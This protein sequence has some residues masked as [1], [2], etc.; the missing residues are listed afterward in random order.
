MNNNILKKSLLKYISSF[1]FIILCNIAILSVT[2]F[3]VKKHQNVTPTINNLVDNISID[4]NSINVTKRGL[5]IIKNNNL[6]ILV[7]NDAGNEVFN[8]DK[9]SNI[10]SH[11]TYS[12]VIKFSKYYLND[13]PVFTQEKAGKTIVIAFPKNRIARYQ[14]NYLDLDSIKTLPIIA[15]GALLFNCLYFF[16]LYHYSNNYIYKHLSPL[17]K[18]ITNLPS[19]LNERIDSISE[20]DR[21]THAIN[22]TDNLLKQNSKF[23][24]EWVAGIAHDLKTPLSVIISNISLATEKTTDK[25]LMKYLDA[26]LIE[27]NYI[28]NLLNDLNVFARLTNN[29][30]QLNKELINIVPF[31]RNIIIQIINQEIWENFIFEFKTDNNLIDKKMNVEKNLISRVV[32]NI[33]YN[34]VLHNPI[35]CDVEISLKLLSENFFTI[36]IQ[37]NGIG[38]SPERLKNINE[39]EKFEFDISGVRRSGMG[40]K[41]SKQIVEAH[42][43]IFNITSKQG[44]YFQTIITLPIQSYISES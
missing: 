14:T 16:L 17:I 39:I 9:P 8:I 34:S 6:W 20:L 37:D 30:L 1:I 28:Q 23:K 21:L 5:D 44:E 29:D 18:A 31:F 40:L 33:I 24:E 4:E 26:S 15:I 10:A 2:V 32:H 19:G 27:S 38:T 35:G 43:G 36:T 12:E 11:F 3:Y 41:I 25:E 7:I 42:N 22:K 13:Y